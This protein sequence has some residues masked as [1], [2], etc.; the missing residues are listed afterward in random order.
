MAVIDRNQLADNPLQIIVN[1]LDREYS[2]LITYI[3]LIAALEREYSVNSQ[4][5]A[6]S[7]EIAEIQV[8]VD[9]AKE[10]ATQRQ[11]YQLHNAIIHVLDRMKTF[12]VSRQESGYYLPPSISVSIKECIE[13]HKQSL[14]A[15]SKSTSNLFSLFIWLEKRDGNINKGRNKELKIWAESIESFGDFLEDNIDFFSVDFLERI[16]R[17]FFPVIEEFQKKPPASKTIEKVRE[18][19]RIR[20]RNAAGFISNLI[21]YAVAESN[22][23]EREILMEI[24][25]ANHPAFFEDR[26]V[27]GSSDF[28]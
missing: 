10:F 20:I 28:D 12:R 15:F 2:E 18:S 8:I 13:R 16:Q 9:R 11:F 3:D 26:T 23:E 4:A 19:Y 6:V 22:A 14:T 17:G 21:D 24:E 5:A 7:E 25:T 27:V 1:S